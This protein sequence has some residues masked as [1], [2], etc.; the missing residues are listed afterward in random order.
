MLFV[1]HF[2][3]PYIK[4]FRSNYFQVIYYN[5]FPRVLTREFE[6]L[7]NELKKIAFN[8][9][10]ELNPEANLAL[11]NLVSAEKRAAFYDK[12]IFPFYNILFKDGIDALVSFFQI[13]SVDP[14]SLFKFNKFELKSILKELPQERPRLFIN[15]AD[16]SSGELERLKWQGGIVYHN[17]NDEIEKELKKL[18]L[19]DA[20][21][22]LDDEK[23]EI[24]RIFKKEIITI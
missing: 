18:Y 3:L 22:G 7:K 4:M 15:V 6:L 24:A 23:Y 14:L 21:F 2:F 9:L 17:K 8:W 11:P 20:Y 13:P 10:I 1:P 19:C 5:E 12:K 16:K